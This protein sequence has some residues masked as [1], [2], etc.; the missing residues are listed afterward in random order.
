MA[1]NF[2]LPTR[3]T[4]WS[5]NAL[6]ALFFATEIREDQS[7]GVVWRLVPGDRHMT[8]SQDFEQVPD[9]PQIYHPK[10]ASPEF[11]AQ[12]SCFVSH[13]LPEFDTAPL[14]FEDHFES[15]TEDRL[16]LCQIVIPHNMKSELRKQLGCMGVDARTLFP[17]LRGVCETI[18]EEM[19]AHTGSY[20]W[21]FA[22]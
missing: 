4:A 18:S 17:G 8:V 11:L 16:H 2:G 1:Q 12:K 9:R 19:F 13:A 5:E 3:F 6:A 14:S 20:E 22:D 7:D 15:E 21:A 10:H